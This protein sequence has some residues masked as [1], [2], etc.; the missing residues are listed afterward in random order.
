[1]RVTKI[2]DV[3]N[4]VNVFALGKNNKEKLKISKEIRIEKNIDIDFNKEEI[5]MN[6]DYM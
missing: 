1:M 6:N 3:V 5:V 2:K 4:F